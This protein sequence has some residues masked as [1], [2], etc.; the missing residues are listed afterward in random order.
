MIVIIV[1]LYI[2]IAVMVTYLVLQRIELKQLKIELK[3]IVDNE[4]N[5]KLHSRTGSVDRELINEINQMLE[6]VNNSRIHFNRKNHEIEQMMTNI[7]HDLRT[8][9]TSALGYIEML[10]N[11]DMSQEEREE[12]L[13]VIGMRMRRLKELIDAFFEFSM[14]ISKNEKP[15]MTEINLV[16]ILQECI[17]HYYD[18]YCDQNR[19]IEFNCE[20]NKLKIHSN[21]NMMMRIFDNL[22][23]NALK[24]G[25]GNL[26][27][28]V[29]ANEEKKIELIFKNEMIDQNIDI[30]R[31]FDEFYTTEISRTKGNTGLGLAIVKQ[32]SQM[33]GWSISAEEKDGSMVI[34]LVIN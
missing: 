18:D 23:S 9:L 20:F 2:V 29:L 12:A 31:V 33:I 1:I 32:F 22:I 16:A 13:H 6:I 25:Y 17:V 11:N 10:E 26:S 30:N 28:T 3:E 21:Q 27:I 15:E 4:S 14:A 8:P 34:R 7:S 24:H 19:S 5:Q